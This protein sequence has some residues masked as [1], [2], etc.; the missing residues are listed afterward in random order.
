MGTSHSNNIAVSASHGHD[1]YINSYSQE[2]KPFLAEAAEL[3]RRAGD[4]TTSPRF[5]DSLNCVNG[6]L[7]EIDNY[8]SLRFHR[9]HSHSCLCSLKRLL[10]SKAEAFLS[11]DYYDSD[12]AWMELVSV[13]LKIIC[14]PLFGSMLPLGPIWLLM[15]LYFSVIILP[16]VILIKF[17][18][19]NKK[20][21]YTNIFLQSILLTHDSCCHFMLLYSLI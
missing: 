16:H 3:L 14:S 19:P 4:L 9:T 1:L 18:F 17:M 5:D 6:S 10:H 2:Y 12:I 7:L 20:N 8:Q 15:R 21:A 13:L 11:N